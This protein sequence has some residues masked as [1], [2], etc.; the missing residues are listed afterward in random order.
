MER[1][2]S[3]SGATI[4]GIKCKRRNRG[5]WYDNIFAFDTETTSAFITPEGKIIP[6]DF[7]LPETY[8]TKCDKI[9]FMYIWM[10]SVDETVYYGRT[11][12]ELK[13]F[14]QELDRILPENKIVY[15]H[16]LSFDWQF[17]RNAIPEWDSV[18]CRNKRKVLTAD[19]GAY[20]FRCS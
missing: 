14:L 6:Y 9:G 2:E 10:F 15:V 19:V 1:W 8:Y 7:S 18:F 13:S 16:N 20:H 17:L 12:D 11:W 4:S 3:I 5:E